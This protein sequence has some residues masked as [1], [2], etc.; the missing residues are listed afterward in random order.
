MARKAQTAI[1]NDFVVGRTGQPKGVVLSMREF[2]RIAALL[3]DVADVTWMKSIAGEEKQAV[4]W[5]DVKR[6]LRKR[7]IL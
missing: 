7:G 5:V 6:R 4:S 3:R 1:R 2:R